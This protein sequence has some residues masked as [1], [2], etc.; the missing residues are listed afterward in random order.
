MTVKEYLEKA[1]LLE[2]ILDAK[3]ENKKLVTPLFEVSALKNF[4]YLEL[5]PIVYRVLSIL[6]GIGSLIVLISETQVFLTPNS[7]L[8]GYL[9]NVESLQLLRI[10]TLLTI[11]FIAY[12]VYYSL[13]RIKLAYTYGLYQKC[14]DGPSLMFAT[15]NFSRVGVAIV[16]NFLDMIKVKSIYEKVMGIPEMGE[17]GGWVLQGMPGILWI[18]FLTHYFDVWSKLIRKLK[19]S[20]KFTFGGHVVA[21]VYSTEAVRRYRGKLEE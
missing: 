16:F 19:L 11:T 18:I 20:D 4:W 2:D 1:I 8:L 17:L 12:M 9:L 7:S 15:I 3:R 21:G 5:Q 14:S 10:F 6:F 13:F